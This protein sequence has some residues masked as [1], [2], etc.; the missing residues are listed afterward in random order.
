[1]EKVKEK[2]K[3]R[4]AVNDFTTSLRSINSATTDVKTDDARTKFRRWKLARHG[5]ERERERENDGNVQQSN[6]ISIGGDG[7]GSDEPAAL[8]REMIK[9]RELKERRKKLRNNAVNNELFD[10]LCWKVAT[11]RN[12]TRRLVFRAFS[13]LRKLVGSAFERVRLPASERT[14]GRA[15]IF[16]LRENY[17]KHFSLFSYV[18]LWNFPQRNE[19]LERLDVL[20]FPCISCMKFESTKV[21]KIHIVHL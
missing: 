21:G 7:G 8:S 1:M 14:I 13:T 19:N 12:A 10:V 4:A 16:W 5:R 11:R 17:S 18:V 6:S 9:A 2:K 15:W 20:D 3:K